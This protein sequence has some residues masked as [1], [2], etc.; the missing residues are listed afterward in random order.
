MAQQECIIKTNGLTKRYGE[1]TAVD[2][3]D[4]T[5]YK[6]EIFGLLGPNGAGKTT[7]TLMLTGLT[8]PTEGTAFIGGIDCIRNPMEVKKSVGYMPDNVGFYADMTGKE[9]LRFTAALNGL[10]REAAESRIEE[11]LERVGLSAAANQRVGTYSRGMRQRL[12]VADVL[13]KDPSVIIMDEPTLGID[14]EGMRYLI[15][16]IH[17]LAKKEGRTIL[18]S[19]HQLYQIQQICDRVGLFVAGKLTACGTIEEL[20]EQT[21][22]DD[23]FVT[24]IR[25]AGGDDGLV[26]ILRGV[27]GVLSVGREDSRYIIGSERDIT[28]ALVDAVR[29]NGYSIVSLRPLGNDLDEIYRR[30]FEKSGGE[31]DEDRSG[32]FKTIFRKNR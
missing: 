28:D 8:E 30:Y 14:P 12:G 31:K 25:I 7:T 29:E 4:L 19:S 3:L 6:G 2:H 13:V 16:L 20:A 32:K 22:E 18:I 24:E 11:L 15:L 5:V 1:K 9:N 23:R 17:D 27:D 21:R 10:D 26:Q